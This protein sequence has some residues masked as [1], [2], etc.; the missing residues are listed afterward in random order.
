MKIKTVKM[1]EQWILNYKD[2]DENGDLRHDY[3]EGIAP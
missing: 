3:D 1:Y 2:L